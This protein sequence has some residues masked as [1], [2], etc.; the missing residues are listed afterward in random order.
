[1]DF[2]HRMFPVAAACLLLAGGCTRTELPPL[3]TVTG[4]V[5]LDGRPLA[6]AVVAFT[7]EG[8]GRTSLGTT[9]A[10]GRYRLTYLRDIAGA[11]PG[12]H[13]VRI[14][15]AS[16]DEGRREILPATY[17]RRSSLE[18]QVEPGDNTIDFALKAK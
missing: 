9:D 7:P 11:N 4:T 2:R 1:M 6:D 17:H 18:A 10:A 5:T 13:V 14:T 8:P 15:T 12:R 16:V 3:G